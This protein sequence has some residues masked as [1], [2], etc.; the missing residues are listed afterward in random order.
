VFSVG[1][2]YTIGPWKLYGGY[3]HI[4]F[5]NPNN[6]LL[7]GAFAVG[8]YNLAFVNNNNYVSDRNQ[9]VFWVGAKYAVTPTL[10]LIGSYYGIRQEFFV[11]GA[12]PGTN[13]FAN[14][15]GGTLNLA[16]A[17]GITAQRAACAANSASQTN[18][19]GQVDMV[20]FALDWRFARH[21]DLY[22]GVSWQQKAG[23]LVSGFVT[24]NNNGQ[25]TTNAAGICATCATKVS[26]FDPGIGLRY[27]F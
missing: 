6:P 9:H 4:S 20:S 7:P 19:A 1:A 14:S 3:E 18:C 13:A 21:V 2:R 15:P 10:D 27:Q 11:Q 25:S 8:G 22:A 5:A 16:A 23:G 26:N 24:S 17:G 12:A